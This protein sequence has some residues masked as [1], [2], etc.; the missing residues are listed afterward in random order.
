MRD[1]FHALPHLRHRRNHLIHRALRGL[2]NIHVIIR[3]RGEIQPRSRDLLRADA[4]LLNQRLQADGHVAHGTAKGVNIGAQKR[5]A[6]E[7]A[8]RNARADFRERLQIGK[9]VLQ[10]HAERVA[11]RPFPHVMRQR[12][13]GDVLGDAGN[14]LQIVG[15]LHE[16]AAQ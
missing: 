1:F 13:G 16:H 3:Q 6:G 4:N 5:H 12:A 14:F 7:I 9:H 2:H 10:R 8:S 15:R 11:F